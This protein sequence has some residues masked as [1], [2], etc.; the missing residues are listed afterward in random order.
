MIEKARQFAQKAHEGQFRKDGITPYFNHCEDVTNL[1]CDYT[2][3]EDIICAGYGHD[4][5]EDTEI[6]YNDIKKEFNEVVAVLI[7][8][9][10][11]VYTK[12]NY[13]ELKRKERK[14]LEAERLGKISYSGKL[15]K[16]ADR[17]TNLRDYQKDPDFGPDHHYVRETRELMEFLKG[18]N[19]E[20]EKQIYSIIG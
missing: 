4:L 8:E 15:I 16:L 1:V 10:T 17:L 6:T 13:P 12:E 14:R 7:K 19:Y 11:N 3:N 20:L 18:T 2:G 5:Y 9:L